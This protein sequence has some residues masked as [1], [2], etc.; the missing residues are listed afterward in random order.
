[1][2]FNDEDAKRTVSL[3]RLSIQSLQH[4]SPGTLVLRS[5]SPEYYT[6]GSA[7]G[8]LFAED[9]GGAD[10]HFNHPQ[11]VWVRQWNPE[12]HAAGPCIYSRGTTIWALGFKTEYESQKLLAEQGA[13]TE[14]LG[15]FIYPLGKIPA[16]RPIFENR[17]SRLSVVYGTSV[18]QANHQ[19]HIRDVHGTEA[20]LIGNDALRWAGSRAKM[21]LYSSDAR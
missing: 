12:S 13:A 15:A 9:I 11:T 21:E 20:K 3:D 7:G 19:L 5:S 4:A 14:I 6:T 17:D 10:W 16:D 2:I 8:R 1:M 18:Y